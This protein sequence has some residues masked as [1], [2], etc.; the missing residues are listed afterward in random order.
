[1][2][3]APTLAE[4]AME[5]RRVITQDVRRYVVEI[6]AIGSGD[7]QGT[8]VVVSTNGEILTCYHVLTALA[9]D[10]LRPG[11]LVADV[12][13]PPDSGDKLDFS[14]TF[15]AGDQE[16]DLALIRICNVP[17]SGLLAGSVA[18]IGAAEDCFLHR[19]V[20]YG[21]RTLGDRVGGYA[22]GQILGPVMDHWGCP[23]LTDRADG[24]VRL[25]AR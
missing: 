12:V 19:F 17:E 3:S 15:V 22:P 8:G 21:F 25:P 6:R 11:Q 2:P 18:S 13:L 10:P 4:Q 1:M 14:A 16:T 9:G 5:P 23:D 24:S 20:S 7:T